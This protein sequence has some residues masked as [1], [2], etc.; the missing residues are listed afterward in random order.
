MQVFERIFVADFNER[1]TI[2]IHINGPYEKATAAD[3]LRLREVDQPSKVAL[4]AMQAQIAYLREIG[5]NQGQRGKLT[6]IK[7]VYSDDTL[8]DGAAWSKLR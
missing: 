6:L 7:N 2:T 5:F 4:D 3:H 8:V 1:M